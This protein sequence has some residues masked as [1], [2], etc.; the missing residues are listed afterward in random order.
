MN[1]KNCNGLEKLKKETNNSDAIVE[2]V[3]GIMYEG[4]K[5]VKQDL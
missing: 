3:L 4:G 5:E 2:F 1:D